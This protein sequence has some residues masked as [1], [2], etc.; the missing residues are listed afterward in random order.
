MLSEG[1]NSGST[2]VDD[3]GVGSV[4][5]SNPGRAVASDNSRAEAILST[6]NI[7]HYLKATGFGFNIP[8]NA[9]IV[10]IEFKIERQGNQ[11]PNGVHIEDNSIKLVKGGTIQGDD[12]F[13]TNAWSGM[14]SIRTYGSNSD[15]WG[16]TWTPADINAS[17]FGGVCSAKIDGTGTHT[18]EIDHMTLTVF[19]TQRGALMTMTQTI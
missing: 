3:S 15:L 9:T 6:G 12:K 8:T 4:T 16:L 1:P 5:W 19:Y 18:A 13:V 14:D 2:F 17:D 10:G 11:N 7:S